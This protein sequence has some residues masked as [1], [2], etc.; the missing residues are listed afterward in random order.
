M[1][2][3]DNRDHQRPKTNPHGVPIGEFTDRPITNV[4]LEPLVEINERA[5]RLERSTSTSAMSVTNRLDQQDVKLLTVEHK[6]DEVRIDVAGIRGEMKVLPELV[7]ALKDAAAAGN[8]RRT[9]TLKGQLAITDEAIEVRRWWRTQ[10][11][12]II[13]AALSGGTLLELLHRFV[14]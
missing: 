3:P 11:A 6:V 8:E 13:G 5:K 9:L 14:L 10:T 4:N 7:G 12:K 2:K 1:T